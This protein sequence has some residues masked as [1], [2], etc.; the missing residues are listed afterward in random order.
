V[1]A[2]KARKSVQIDINDLF[3]KGGK[4]LIDFLDYCVR[5]VQTDPLFL[6]LVQEY[7]NGPTARKA[8]ALFEMTCARDAPAQISTARALY[9]YDARLADMMR[10]LAAQSA[11][12]PA[13]LPPKF[14]FDSVA[15]G[16]EK[17]SASLPKIRRSYRPDRTPVENLP[18][19]KMSPAQ[20]HF[21]ER[22]WQ[23]VVRP[24]LTAAGFWRIATI[25]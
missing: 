18:G 1:K 10:S 25:A 14:L 16:L 7:R 19:G 5:S 12:T 21:V 20:R 22:V 4:P 11:A 24:R 13:P 15:A 3:A 9:L 23:P 8:V 2:R 17:N 6:F